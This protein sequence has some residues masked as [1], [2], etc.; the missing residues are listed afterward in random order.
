N[1]LCDRHS[2]QHIRPDHRLVAFHIPG[3]LALA[4]RN[5]YQRRLRLALLLSLLALLHIIVPSGGS[6]QEGPCGPGK[7]LPC[8]SVPPSNS[9][10]IGGGAS[11]ADQ[12]QQD[13]FEIVPRHPS[14]TSR[15][16]IPSLWATNASRSRTGTN[17]SQCFSI[18][19]RNCSSD[20]CSLR[21]V[22]SLSS[23]MAASR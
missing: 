1:F 20:F 4:P 8:Q 7:R 14:D 15:L 16:A 3:G 17:R 21:G 5:R 18:S 9:A 6:V 23:L 13:R 22:R 11:G 10:A 19:T 12:C 2:F